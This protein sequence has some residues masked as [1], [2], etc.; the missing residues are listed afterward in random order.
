ML[1]VSNISVQF[2][3]K[4]L[5]DDVSFIVN[6]H[7][8]IGLVGSNGTGKSTLLK[9]INGLVESDSG[10]IA[11]SKHTTVDYLPQDGISFSGKT[12]YEEVYTGLSDISA[13]KDEIDEAQKELEAQTDRTSAEYMDLVETLGELQHKFEDLD[14]FKIK[15]RTPIGVRA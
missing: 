13:V 5:F 3:S 1:S 6:P 11:I 9:I 10:Q 14:G 12:L 7:D 2:G 8:R 15:T 4:K